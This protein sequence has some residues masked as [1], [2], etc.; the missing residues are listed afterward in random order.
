[1]SEVVIYPLSDLCSNITSNL[2]VVNGMRQITVADQLK[3]L[4]VQYMGKM[5][6]GS[7]L[8]LAY[9][10][11][12]GHVRKLTYSGS[13]RDEQNFKAHWREIIG[14]YFDDVAILIAAFL[15]ILSIIYAGWINW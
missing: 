13:W 14:Y 8:L 12:N 10:I 9:T 3:D 11:F 6:F 1:M 15:F 4:N 2:S 5:L 7:A